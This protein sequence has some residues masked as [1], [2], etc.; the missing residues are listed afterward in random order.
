MPTSTRR[1][2]LF[3]VLGGF[4]LTNAL[5]GEVTG[6]KL[7]VAPGSQAVFGHD[8]IL[9]IG[10][11]MWPVVFVT[12]DLVNEYFGREGVRRLTFLAL[13]MIGY[14]FVVL[15]LALAVPTASIG[16]PGQSFQDVFG[17]SL[18]MIVGSLLAFATSQLIDVLLFSAFRARTGPALL[19]LRATGS[20]VVSQLV[21]SFVVGF[22]G[23][24][25]PG[26]LS[27]GD[28]LPIGAANYAYKVVI[29]LLATPVIYA[30]HAAID[31]WLAG[32]PPLDAAAPAGEA[33]ALP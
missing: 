15:F 16:V 17:T 6:G 2:L 8:V 9:S 5:L 12:T 14:A 1:D 19:W 20:T 26:K 4:F 3:L 29:A 33:S 27:L 21:D 10:V 11:L 28:F 24:V 32:D 22:V 13:F 31:R 30:A 25:V 18:W 23:F 7:F